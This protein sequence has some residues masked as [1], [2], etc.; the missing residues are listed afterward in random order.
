MNYVITGSLGNISMPLTKELIKNGHHVLVITSAEERKAAI[1]SLG[2]TAAVGSVS[3]INFLTSTFSNADAVYTMVPPFFGASDWKAYI[4]SIG[5]NYAK[6]IE[7]SGV[8][9]VVNLSSMGAHMPNGCG[10]VSGLYYVEKALNGLK[11]VDV[12]HLRPGYFYKNFMGNIGMVKNMNILGSNYGGSTDMI[13]A[14]TSD[15]AD[16]AADALQNLTFAGKSVKYVVSDQR[17]ASEVATLLGSAVGK[18]ELPWI[19][20]KDDDSYGA[21]IQMGLP[22]EIAKNYVE[23]GTAMRSG[24]M[25]EEYLH[26]PQVN[27]KRG[28]DDFAQ[29]FAGAYSSS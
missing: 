25:S 12:L 23:M 8:K 1:E 5:E 2:A 6:A 9:K 28:I 13:M 15:I 3:D 21:M 19:E 16:F 10:P 17:K 14:D 20:F 18:P 4:A 29:A 7:A 27:G 24:A 22:E 11:D 26:A